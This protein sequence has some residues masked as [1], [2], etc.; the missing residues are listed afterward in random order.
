MKIH[1]A[2]LLAALALPIGLAAALPAAAQ[3]AGAAMPSEHTVMVGGAPMYP[4]KNI[5]QNAVNSKDHTTLVAAV[6]AAGLVDT[7]E[8]AGPF[9][10]FAPT[11]EAFDKLTTETRSAT[12]LKPENKA[13]LATILTYHVVS[14]RYTTQDLM[15]LAKKKRGHGTVE[16]SR[17]R[18]ADNLVD[19]GH[20]YVK[21]AQE[22]RC[23]DHHSQ[24][25][26]VERRHS[27]GQLGAAAELTLLVGVRHPDCG[28]AYA[29]GARHPV[30]RS[31]SGADKLAHR[32][33][34]CLRPA[35]IRPARL[36][37]F[38]PAAAA[39]AAH[40]RRRRSHQLDRIEPSG[41][42]RRHAHHDA[43]LAFRRRYQRHHA[44][45]ELPADR[46]R[47]SLQFARRH[48]AHIA[49]RQA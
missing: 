10:V 4:S 42:I 36:R 20:V 24:R 37:Q 5:I 6:K 3:T 41:Q 47:Q 26:A 43:G 48:L 29:T 34:C 46:V 39:F 14:G 11:N 38:R 44:A 35:A 16:D 19:N 45:A 13:M 7:L 1:H 28:S 27:G 30:M 32:R 9:T 40:R 31:T 12:L 8:G 25:H 22:R 49:R 18:T 33:Q 15:R 17:R 2:T 23:G 21:G